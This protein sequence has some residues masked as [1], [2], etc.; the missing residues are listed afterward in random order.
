MNES[1][2]SRRS[3]MSGA[4]AF[5]IGSILDPLAVLARPKSFRIV[6]ITDIHIQ[7]ELHAGDGFALCVK[8]IQSLNPKPDLIITGGDHVMDVLHVARP[9][10]DLQFAMFAERIKPLE[11]P[12]HHC[13]GN[14]DVY[15]WATDSPIKASDPAYGKALYEEKVREGRSY[16]S[17][18]HKGWH[19]IVLDSIGI[20]AGS[21]TGNVDDAQLQWLKDDLSSVSLTT[22]IIVTVH[23]PILTCFI[24]ET[25]GTIAKPSAQSVLGNGKAVFDLLRTRSV[26]L[27]L[28]GHTH[29]VESVDYLGT[30]FFTAGAVS[31]EW[32]KGPRLG[33]HPE[34]FTVIDCGATDV[35]VEYVPYGW[36]AMA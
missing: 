16:Y 27:V 32:W 4:G 9:R 13:V 3:L 14:H 19:F 22:P 28:Q 7:P 10:A 25:E 2:I 24:Q 15:G 17:F 5:G 33:V 36:K 23:M 11:I 30:K 1:S 6:H 12:V 35:K 29:V 26:K 31:G 34:G 8:K 20:E 21:W 18:D